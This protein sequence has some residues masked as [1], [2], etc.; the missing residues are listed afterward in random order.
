M[1]V[2]RLPEFMVGCVAGALFLRLRAE[3]SPLVDRAG[4][5]FRNGLL[6][7]GLAWCA[8]VMYSPNVISH[9]SGSLRGTLLLELGHDVL[10]VP[11]LS[12]VIFSLALGR[13]FLHPILEH[14]W[15]QALG[16]ASYSLYVIHYTLLLPVGLYY[17]KL[18][19]RP[20]LWVPI[21]LFLGIVAAALL[22]H[23]TVELPARR[24]IL[25]RSRLRAAAVTPAPAVRP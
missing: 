5:A 6:L 14:R 15:A 10:F 22:V 16:L 2:F 17:L 24:G 20:A 25:R 1:P 11:G 12:A 9:P 4:L 3:R 19:H 21:L 8:L 13:T 18:G 7:L 23:K